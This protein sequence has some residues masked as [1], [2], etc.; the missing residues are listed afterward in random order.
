VVH[1]KIFVLV[2]CEILETWLFVDV[3]K[4]FGQALFFELLAS[5]ESKS[6]ADGVARFR[7]ITPE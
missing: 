6:V 4:S 1:S 5:H 2:C 3:I 7:A